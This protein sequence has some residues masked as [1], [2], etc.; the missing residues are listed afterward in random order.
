MSI[1]R[2]RVNWG[3]RDRWGRIHGEVGESESTDESRKREENQKSE[4]RMQNP[5]NRI[6]KLG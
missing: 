5:R 4:Q 1:N 2:I 3:N 6:A